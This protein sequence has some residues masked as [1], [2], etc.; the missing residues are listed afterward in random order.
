MFFNIIGEPRIPVKMYKERIQQ[1]M[2]FFIGLCVMVAAAMGYEWE[3][4]EGMIVACVLAILVFMNLKLRKDLRVLKKTVQSMAVPAPEK[5]AA[6]RTDAKPEP[7]FHEKAVETPAPPQEQA[8]IPLPS[9]KAMEGPEKEVMPDVS[10]E[11]ETDDSRGEHI[12]APRTFTAKE[13]TVEPALDLGDELSLPPE[14]AE[15]HGMDKL[16]DMAQKFVTQGNVVVKIALVVLFFGVAFLLKYASDRN[17]FPIELRYIAAAVVAI[18]FMV[19]GWRLRE[20]NRVYALLVQGGA[21]GVLYMTVFAAAK[22]HHLIPMG[23][24]FGI[25][26]GLVVFSGMLSVLQNA[27]LTAAFGAA[28]G[29]LAPILTSTGSGNH[30]MLFSYYALLNTGIVG[31][32]WFKTW[33]ELNLIG[34]VFTFGIASLWGVKAYKPAFFS[35]TEP[36]LILFFIYFSVLSVLFAVKQPPKLK[37]YVDGSLV[38]GLPIIAFTLQGGLVKDMPYG[39]AISALSLSVYYLIGARG[40]W[41]RQI[42]G[43]R[44]LTE[45][46]LALG[47]VF[48]SLAIPLSLDG[49]W[50]AA[51]WAM[52]GAALVWVGV[53]Q[54]RTL[55]R[56]FGILLQVGAGLSFLHVIHAPTRTFPVINGF[57]LGC[58]AVASAGLF[59]AYYLQQNRDR[60]HVWEQPFGDAG[61]AW[62]LVWWYGA[63]LREIVQFAHHDFELSLAIGFFGISA[64]F[65]SIL[66]SRLTWPSLKIPVFLLIFMLAPLLIMDFLMTGY[67]HPF[68][69]GGYLAWPF[70]LAVFYGILYR[71][72]KDLNDPWRQIQHRTGLWVVLTLVTIEAGFVMGELS[73]KHSVWVFM[74]WGLVPALSVIAIMTKAQ[75]LAWPF[76]QN[77]E[78]Y[79][80]VALLP[81]T[82]FIGLWFLKG[83]AHISG[84]PHP[85]P[86][87]PIINPLELIQ[88][89]VVMTVT[90]WVRGMNRDMTWF[91]DAVGQV[92]GTAFAAILIFIWMNTVLGR[93]VHMYGNIPYHWDSLWHSIVFQACVSVLWT[94]LALLTMMWAARKRLRP[95]WFVGAG[96][97]A[98]VVLKLFFV[99]LSRSGTIARIV[100]FLVTGLLMLVIGYFSPLPPSSKEVSK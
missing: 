40:L 41:D 77:I 69:Y 10:Q 22:L 82:V 21:L 78:D 87:I 62:G 58:L 63:G 19:L 65:L 70:A 43:M 39:L 28:G 74:V 83:C 1:P 26:V 84:D 66:Y 14:E 2:W 52:E 16:M 18:G 80:T 81:V 32:A 9:Y 53:R 48:G 38:F 55:A 75:R 23:L 17:M 15:L 72:E 4:E 94:L 30:V 57:Y 97:L 100:S 6:A 24:T 27:R 47:V 3:H 7:V 96:L 25:L 12:R 76:G 91:R 68:H 49:R 11:A 35:T 13:T 5:K 71:H 44:T 61:L 20:T 98:C 51:A 42:E 29:F 99:D 64:V 50:T 93:T 85:L 92:K 8:E 34:F 56:A 73:S 46:F 89:F 31:I 79:K 45:A 33:R 59:S 67:S 37:G 95:H 90:F 36:F 88:L 54:K 86:Y 60:L